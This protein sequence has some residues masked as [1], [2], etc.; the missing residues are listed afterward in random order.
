MAAHIATQRVSPF[1]P[2][3]LPPHPK[4]EDSPLFC[5]RQSVININFYSRRA[6][7]PFRVVLAQLLKQ[8]KRYPSEC[9]SR[10]WTR[11]KR[12]R[13]KNSP[14]DCFLNGLSVGTTVGASFPGSIVIIRV[15]DCEYKFRNKK[16]KQ[17]FRPALL[18]GS[19]SWTRTND[20]VINS[21]ALYRLSYWGIFSFH[22]RHSQ[23]A[24]TT[25]AS[26]S[27]AR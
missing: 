21:H 15:I 25:C 6:R 4:N 9:I 18:F 8:G 19:P 16:K 2:T 27:S 24:L 7:V 5:D 1:G 10:R 12:P 17:V 26:R 14:L 22:T 20:I 11:R 23:S 13:P 3:A